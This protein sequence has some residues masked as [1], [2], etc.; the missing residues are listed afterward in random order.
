MGR[1]VSVILISYRFKL[2]TVSVSPHVSQVVVGLG[3]Y[4]SRFGSL[5]CVRASSFWSPK[6]IRVGLGLIVRLGLSLPESWLNVYIYTGRPW[7]L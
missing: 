6:A 1:G 7:I 2:I 3:E 4:E 5:G